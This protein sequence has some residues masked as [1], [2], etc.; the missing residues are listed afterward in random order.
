MEPRKVTTSDTSVDGETDKIATD[1][2]A[3][4]KLQPIIYKPGTIFQGDG[5][6]KLVTNSAMDTSKG[7]KSRGQQ[8]QNDNV[9]IGGNSLSLLPNS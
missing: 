8:K 1:A 9:V 6:S 7:T 3:T 2:T 4:T 5:S